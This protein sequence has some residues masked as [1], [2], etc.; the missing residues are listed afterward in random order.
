MFCCV[1]FVFVV[2][3][4]FL[5]SRDVFVVVCSFF[6]VGCFFYGVF[7]FLLW[8]VR[9]LYWMFVFC[10]C[11]MFCFVLWDARFSL[12]DVRSFE[13]CSLFVG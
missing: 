13:G 11:A 3:C 9:C 8:D 7:V 12:W 6:V 2:G 5:F 4:W 1:M 10:C